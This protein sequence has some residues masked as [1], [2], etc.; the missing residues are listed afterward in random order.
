MRGHKSLLAIIALCL[1]SAVA[2][3]VWLSFSIF[4]F[5]DWA[6]AFSET[7]KEYIYPSAWG[8]HGG[9]LTWQYPLLLVY[10][11]FA[12]PGFSFNIVE[13]F[14]NLWPLIFVAP[15]SSFL[16][17]RKV[18]RSDLAGFIG[19]LFFTF[20]TYFLS[21]DTQGH[22]LLTIAFA[23]APLAIIAFINLLQQKKIIWVP[24]S[25]FSLFV[26]GSYDPRSMYI[27]VGV[28]ALYA[29][30]HQLVEENKIKI[31]LWINIKYVSAV[32]ILF[33]LL[34]LF[35]I[36]PTL[37]L[38]AL[39]NNEYLSRQIFGT[40][41]Y[42]L[43]SSLTSFYPF[44]TG[45]E[46]TWFQVQKIPIHFWLFPIL[47]FVG[48]ILNKKN[49]LL[50]FFAVL[51]LLGV[52]LAKQEAEPLRFVYPWL[53][54]HIPGFAAFREAS[55]FDFLINISYAVL[56]GSLVT[57]IYSYFKNKRKAYF[58][59]FLLALLPLLNAV[60]LLTGEINTT[61]V[62]KQLPKD[63]VILKNYIVRDPQ[64]SRVL[65]INLNQHFNF[66]TVNHPTMDSLYSLKN[67]WGTEIDFYGADRSDESEGKKMIN[68]FSSDL[69][70]RLLNNSSVGYLPVFIA[71][72]GT[73]QNIRRDLGENREFFENKLSEVA[74]LKK[75]DLGFQNVLLYKNT[76]ARPHLYLTQNEESLLKD[77]PYQKVEFKP[78]GQSEY[79]VSI[80]NLQNVTYLNF[81]ELYI[82]NWKVYI[83]DF[84]WIRAFLG[85]Q[86]A[87]GES[88][89]TQSAVRFNSFKINPNEICAQ[90]K[91]TKNS[92]G[93][94][95]F[96]ITVYFLPQAY[97]NFGLIISGS[98]LALTTGWVV[99]LLLRKK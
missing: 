66:T 77:V 32:L 81:T 78:L 29:L 30:Y 64:Y 89:H 73:N 14:V 87:I 31:N 40:E 97:M 51:A 69:G 39:T 1:I 94:Y 47:A 91:C 70:R 96:S 34:N 41:F 95:N 49:K 52:F 6:F 37:S 74:Y 24:L 33:G 92:D 68:Y 62:P 60:P 3:R 71:D 17:V 35:W 45:K 46:P 12:H 27:L 8:I 42:N 36:L 59:I 22:E 15:I 23:F 11:L 88:A 84:S 18:T 57:Y 9:P 21:I 54:S 28:F 26:V 20:N 86:K 82:P 55:K 16:L 65:G 38:H 56:I 10:G 80:K 50:G 76:Q 7:L 4:T 48:L 61:F 43:Q 79:R 5:G 44:W 67:F 58:I 99:Y 98:V 53:Y 90:A 19:A 85:K 93:S 63:F 83:G 13:K 2:Y 25:A 75:I 72:K